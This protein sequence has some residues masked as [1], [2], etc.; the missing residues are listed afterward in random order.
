MSDKRPDPEWDSEFKNFLKQW[1]SGLLEGIEKV[2][3]DT[4]PD[5]LKMTGRACARIHSVD[6]FKSKWEDSKNLDEFI[7]KINESRNGDSFEK[8]DNNTISVSYTQC[9]CPLAKYGLV[10]SPILCN[11]SPNWL[12]ENFEAIFEKS[13][14]VTTKNTILN[15]AKTCNFIVNFLN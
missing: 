15:G 2:N 5:V 8:I 7:A 9:Y 6:S 1:F 12:I 3:D 13:V 11:C 10:N 4:W 14:T